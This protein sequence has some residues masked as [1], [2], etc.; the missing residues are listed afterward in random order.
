M[1]SMSIKLRMPVQETMLMFFGFIS[2]FPYLKIFLFK[3][4]YK[5]WGID[6]NQ[7]VYKITRINNKYLFTT[8]GSSLHRK[9]FNGIT[10]DL[11]ISKSTQAAIYFSKP[12]YENR[13]VKFIKK[14]LR[15]DMVFIDAGAHIGYYS[16]LAAKLVGDKGKVIAFEPEPYNYKG[17]K[18]NVS[19]NNFTNIDTYEIGL[20]DVTKGK[21]LYVN[22]YNDG[23]HTLECADK[24]F[25][26]FC[27]DVKAF[28]LD[29]FL[30]ETYA[31]LCVNFVKIDVEKHTSSVLEGMQNTLAYFRPHILVEHNG[32]IQLIKNFLRRLGY[33]EF[34]NTGFDLFCTK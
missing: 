12:C 25:N 21:K 9:V 1:E 3:I 5:V 32:R 27:I 17:F 8:E 34:V 30:K 7:L 10:L 14:F 23:G 24:E 33:S 2:R 19:L 16:L 18:H 26:V 20:S 4:I 29:C 15:K 11:D 6:E 31:N 22:S 13:N 28:A